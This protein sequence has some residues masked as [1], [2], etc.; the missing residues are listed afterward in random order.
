MARKITD[1]DLANRGVM[2]LP[3][4]PGLTAIEMQKKLEEIPREVIIPRYNELVDSVADI[5]EEFSKLSTYDVGDYCIYENVLYKCTTAITTEGEWDATKWKA[6]SIDKELKE[7]SS[8]TENKDVISD[9]YDSSKTYS[10]GDYCIYNDTL[11]KCKTQ[12]TSAEEFDSSK[13]EPT[14]CGKEFEVLNSNLTELQSV[15]ITPVS[16]NYAAVNTS[17]TYAYIKNGICYLQIT[18]N[19]TAFYSGW[20]NVAKLPIQLD[21]GGKELY[22]PVIDFSEQ[23]A[24]G[25]VRVTGDGK[26]YCTPTSGAALYANVSFPCK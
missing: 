9:K 15:D 16:N 12:I 17:G 11:Y 2:G 21:T 3:D 22:F 19:G 7:I 20:V 10:V 4:V 13:W 6:T 1:E 25:V 5:C 24:H 8:Y 23:K 14:N 26:V 18:I